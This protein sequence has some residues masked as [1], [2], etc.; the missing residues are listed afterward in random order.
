MLQRP[1]QTAAFWRDQFEITQDDIEYFYQLLLEAQRPMKLNELAAALIQEYLRRENARIEQELSKGAIYTP[2]QRYEM[3]QTLVF[4]SLEFA[5][6]KVIEVRKGQNPEHGDFDVIKVSFNPKE[7]A[8]E[9]AAGLQTPHRLNQIDGD[10]LVNDEALLSAEEIY[11]L[12]RGD[13]NETILYALED[14]PRSEEFVNVDDSW[15][16]ADMLAPVHVGHLNIAEA[17]I[18]MQGTPLSTTQLLAEVELDA[19]VSPSMRITSINYALSRDDRFVRILR[20]REQLWFLRRLEPAEVQSIPPLL[21]Y[22]STVYNRGLLSVEM[23][24]LEWEL[25]DEWGESSLSSEVP[26]VVPSTSLVLTYP[27]RRYGTLPL[28]GR[29]RTFF[30]QAESGVSVVTLV[31]GRWGTR[32]T[33]YVV[34]AGRYVTGLAKWMDDHQLPVGA[35]ITLE[36]T[37]A[38]DEVIVDFRTRRPKR[39]WARIASADLETDQLLFEMN[40]INVACEYD[41]YMI[42][43]ERSAEELDELRSHMDR[44]GLETTEIVNQVTPELLKLN[45][46]GTVHAKSVYSAVNVLRRVPPGVIFALLIGNRRFREVGNG[47]FALA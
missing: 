5:V 29:T 30:P 38:A 18:E 15:L 14:G 26:A 42:V 47:L 3:G 41:E 32:Y 16:L 10:R 23:L 2:K 1:S 22:R 8:R 39:E 24:Q 36:R 31:D 45:P 11:S 21:Q 37:A 43:A 12:Y 25:D 6:G 9:F 17:L 46:Q 27:H 20:R 19:N 7:K 28:S 4:P 40:K 34:H 35:F 13:I 33:G 44:L